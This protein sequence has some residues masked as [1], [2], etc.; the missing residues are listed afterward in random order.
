VLFGI[1]VASAIGILVLP[2]LILLDAIGNPTSPRDAM[3]AS[4]LAP[5]GSRSLAEVIPKSLRIS[6]IA[7]IGGGGLVLNSI[8]ASVDIPGYSLP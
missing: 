4:S 3:V 6:A 7:G 1:A 2:Y 5:A 8:A